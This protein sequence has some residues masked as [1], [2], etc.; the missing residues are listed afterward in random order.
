VVDFSLMIWSQMEVENAAEVGA[1]AAYKTCSGGTLPA[2]SGSNCSNLTSAITTAIQS[3]TLST[4]VALATGSPSETY[5]CTNGNALS[6]VGSYSSKPS[7][8]NCSSIGSASETPGDYIA[9]NVTYSFTPI[10]AGL[11][12]AP[13]KTLVGSAMQRL[14]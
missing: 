3:T 2:M 9:V 8:F 6:S 13:T 4:N 10:F 1:Q 5:Y 11:S 12:L 7:P 14:Q